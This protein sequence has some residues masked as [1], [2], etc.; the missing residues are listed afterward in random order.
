MA[1]TQTVHR[2]CDQFLPGSSFTK[3]QYGSVTWGRNFNLLESVPEYRAVSDHFAKIKF[4]ADFIFQI[5]LFLGESILEPGNFLVGARIVN[6]DGNLRRDLSQQHDLVFAKR[7]VVHAGETQGSDFPS[8]VR[9]RE[10]AGGTDAC[11]E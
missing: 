1:G 4:G 3:H 7:I 2:A 9:Q 6:C 10:A 5:E 8:S 11:I